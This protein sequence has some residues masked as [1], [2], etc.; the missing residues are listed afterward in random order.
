[1]TGERK[2]E[3]LELL[4]GLLLATQCDGTA[5]RIDACRPSDKQEQIGFDKGYDPRVE[6]HGRK[7][8]RGND[9]Y[10]EIAKEM[11]FVVVQ[12]GPCVI[13]LRYTPRAISSLRK[14]VARLPAKYFL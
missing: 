13:N 1:M 7:R 4:D 11:G 3:F 8:K 12:L 6:S 14:N 10:Y 2:K 5:G 9:A